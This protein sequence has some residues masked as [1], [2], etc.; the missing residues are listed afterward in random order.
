MKERKFYLIAVLVALFMASCSNSNSDEAN[1]GFV[2]YDRPTITAGIQKKQNRFAFTDNEDKGGLVKTKWANGDVIVAWNNETANAQFDL[3]NGNDSYKAV[4]QYT[5]ETGHFSGM[6]LS[7]YA[8]GATKNADYQDGNKS[9]PPKTLLVSGNTFIQTSTG[10]WN[11]KTVVKDIRT[12]IGDGALKDLADKTV[13]I[14]D[15]KVKYDINYDLTKGQPI[16]FYPDYALITFII[17]SSLYNSPTGYLYGSP[18][19]NVKRKVYEFTFS[20]S[21]ETENEEYVCTVE[22]DLPSDN[23]PYNNSVDAVIYFPVPPS[24]N[25]YDRLRVKVTDPDDSTINGGVA[26]DLTFKTDKNTYEAGKR[27]YRV[28]TNGTEGGVVKPEGE[29]EPYL[30]EGEAQGFEDGGEIEFE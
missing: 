19:E 10:D 20:N 30:I 14:T 6:D 21:V 15:E 1:G 3:T 7:L 13:L 9:V 29:D 22:L 27:Y 17:D 12:T 5:G 16:N 2:S 28:F 26:F 24:E 18:G 11:D 4:F 25:E 23:Y 8:M